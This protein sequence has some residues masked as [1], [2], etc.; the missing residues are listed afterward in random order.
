LIALVKCGQEARRSAQTGDQETRRAE[1][2]IRRQG[3][4]NRRSG[5][6]ESRTGDQEIRRRGER[7]RME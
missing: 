7:N 3:E 5:D 2:E 4:P 1:Q 6:K